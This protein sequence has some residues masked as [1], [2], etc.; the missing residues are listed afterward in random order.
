MTRTAT[1]LASAGLLA[2]LLSPPLQGQ[3]KTAKTPFAETQAT[4]AAPSQQ[5]SQPSSQFGGVLFSED[6]NSTAPGAIPAGWSRLST[7]AAGVA[8]WSVY[9]DNAG[10]SNA[11]RSRDQSG[12]SR[13][14]FLITPQI[15][16]DATSTILS[17]DAKQ[18]YSTNYG[19]VYSIRVSTTDANETTDFTEV[20]SFDETDFGGSFSTFAV[21]LAAYA[22]Q[23]V[24]I[25]FVHAQNFGD[26]WLMD[27]VVIDA[28]EQAT[29]AATSTE[30]QQFDERDQGDKHAVIAAYVQVGGT[31]GTVNVSSI[32]FTTAGS[33]NPSEDALVAEAYY[34]GAFPEVDVDTDP[35]F[36][37]AI[38]NPDGSLTFTGSLALPSGDNFIW[39]VYEIAQGATPGNDLD[40]TFE[41]VTVDGT[42]YAPATTS[43]AGAIQVG[44]IPAFTTAGDNSATG[45][46]FAR[47]GGALDNCTVPTATTYPYETVDISVTETGLYDILATWDGYDGYLL[48]YEDTFDPNDP[49][50]NLIAFSDDFEGVGA[51]RIEDIVLEVPPG[52]RLPGEYIVVMSTFSAASPGGSYTLEVLKYSPTA[53][54]VPVEMTAFAPRLDGDAVV[55][56]WATA[57]E[58]NNAGFDVQMRR[59]GQDAFETVT[60]VEGAGTTA[61]PRSY[62]FRVAG[63]QPGTHLFRLRQVDLD[64]QATLTNEVEASVELAQPFALTAARPNPFAQATRFELAVQQA[65]DVRVAVY[66]VLGREVV[67]LHDGAFEAQSSRAFTLSAGQMA[68]GT[69]VVRVQGE[70]FAETMRVTVVR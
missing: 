2:A 69:Y 15:T 10:G 28:P 37:Q 42:A 33:T 29:F 17:F 60:F 31:A 23:Q 32:T 59:P 9:F 46:T 67:V 50:T 1:L 5:N 30:L 68:A 52:G 26:Q 24:Y 35:S 64:G 7:G 48:L 19:S 61:E 62:S 36:G 45:L 13:Q 49:C 14:D 27:N 20:A 39:L 63:L 51:S 70:R 58:T 34:S 18:F 53:T 43:L 12:G 38:F 6:F 44:P 65:Q 22:N 40:G 66:D 16:L 55:L 41:S 21:D 3:E 57:S 11:V 25:A 8:N 56:E 47:P 54:V 4:F